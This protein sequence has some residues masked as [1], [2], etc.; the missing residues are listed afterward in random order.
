LSEQWARREQKAL[1]AVN[2]LLEAAGLTMDAVMA[3]TLALK[4]DSVERLD[5][6]LASAQAR[7]EAALR[8]IDRHRQTL[9]ASLRR[10]AVEVEDAEFVE[11]VPDAADSKAA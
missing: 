2:K 5:R 1:R 7:R 6:M 9:A 11:V 8:E 10:A 4:L 3:Q